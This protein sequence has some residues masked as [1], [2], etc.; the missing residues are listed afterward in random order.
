[1]IKGLA[2]E[3]RPASDGA[4]VD[5]D[6]PLLAGRGVHVPEDAQRLLADVDHAPEVGVKDGP[7]LAVL[8]ALGVTGQRVAGIVDDH[9]DAAKLFQGRVERGLDGVGR[10]DVQRKFEDA[11]VVW[12]R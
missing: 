11:V 6:A 9:V 5:D 3:A 7:R 4:H 12:D 8:G 2:G 1:M 10:S